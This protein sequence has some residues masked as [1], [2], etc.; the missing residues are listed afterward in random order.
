MVRTSIFYSNNNSG[1]IY[2]C[3]L[4]K[5]ILTFYDNS[6]FVYFSISTRRNLN[7][8]NCHFCFNSI[9]SIP[10]P[11]PH[12]STQIPHIPTLIPC[13]PTLTPRIPTPI[14]QISTP[15]PTFPTF[16]LLFP[17]FPTPFPAFPSFRSSVSHFGF[18]R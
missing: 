18:Y 4:I 6:N 17:A 9:P 7:L 8:I 2:N 10:T 13:I 1:R 14:P 11:I 12:I 16:P 5:Q 3:N 15:F